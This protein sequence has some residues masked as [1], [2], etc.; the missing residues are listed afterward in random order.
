MDVASLFSL[1][2]AGVKYAALLLGAVAA[3][4]LFY[5]S[6]KSYLG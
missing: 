4:Q 1:A 6:I 2:L 3:L 5:R